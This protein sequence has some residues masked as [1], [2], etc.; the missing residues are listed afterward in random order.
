MERTK[1][2]EGRRTVLKSLVVAAQFFLFGC[3][4]AKALD[5]TKEWAVDATAFAP[6]VATLGETMR[7]AAVGAARFHPRDF[8]R[9]LPLAPSNPTAARQQAAR[10]SPFGF[11][12]GIVTNTGPIFQQEFKDDGVGRVSVKLPASLRGRYRTN[13]DKFE[14]SFEAERPEVS[15]WD[16]PSALNMPRHYVLESIVDGPFVFTML[17]LN[18]ATGKR[19]RLNALL[20]TDATLAAARADKSIAPGDALYPKIDRLD[21]ET[22]LLLATQTEYCCQGICRNEDGDIE[23]QGEDYWI[24]VNITNPTKPFC[25]IATDK[26]IRQSDGTVLRKHGVWKSREEAQDY[27]DEVLLGKC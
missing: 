21:H 4:S 22:A 19:L 14:V 13:G 11:A 18:T 7:Q 27:L 20:V 26:E 2:H 5:E 8:F 9:I 12:D 16:I 10:R 3:G 25:T 24:C 1:D 15:L 17:L 6:N 23:P